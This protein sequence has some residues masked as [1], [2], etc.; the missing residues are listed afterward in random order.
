MN[1][2]DVVAVLQLVLH[3]MCTY[4]M[5]DD[6]VT[7]LN[8]RIVY[9]TVIRKCLI[10]VTEQ[11]YYVSTPYLIFVRYKCYICIMFLRHVLYLFVTGVILVR[12]TCYS[13]V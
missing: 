3:L 10:R 12:C 5:D 7:T 6:F 9:V 13:F 2:R 4:Y 1:A 8:K 11:L